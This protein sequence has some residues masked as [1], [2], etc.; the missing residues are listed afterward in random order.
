MLP[1]NEASDVSRLNRGLQLTVPSHRRELQTYVNTVAG[2][3]SALANTAVGRIVLASGTYYLSAELNI[4]RSV[5]LEAAVAGSVVLD[6]QA[7]S[8]ISTRV[9]NVNPGSLGVVQLIGLNVTGGYNNIDG[10]GVFINSGTVTLSSCTITG[11]TADF[12]GGGV[13]VSGGTVTFSSCTITGST[14]GGGVFVQGGS[15]TFDSC[16]ITGNTAYS[17]GGGVVIG[18]G[19]VSFSSCTITGNTADYGGGA[20]VS[21]GTV[22]FSSCSITGNTASYYGGGVYVSGGTV[23]FSSCTIT[24]NTAYY[25]GGGG[26]VYI[27]NGMVSFSSCTITGNTAYNGGGVAVSGG[28]VTISSC[29]ISGNAATDWGGGIYVDGGKVSIVNSQVYSNQA[30]SASNVYV[31]SI[32]AT[33]CSWATTLIGGVDGTVSTCQTPPPS[34][35]PLPPS[36][37]PSPPTSPP[38]P[39]PPDLAL[40][41]ATI[42]SNIPT[43]IAF[44]GTALTDGATCAFLPAGDDTCAGAAGAA[45]SGLFPTGGVLSRGLVT[46]RLSGP[47]IYKL[48]AAPA[49]SDPKLD[50]HF[51]YVSSVLL[52]SLSPSP[53]KAMDIGPIAGG[54][55]GGLLLLAGLCGL[56]WKLRRMRATPKISGLELPQGL[57]GSVSPV[58]LLESD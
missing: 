32:G 10:G 3:T 54:V 20:Y 11:N 22:T 50:A 43:A 23:T 35:P 41:P 16:T 15:V 18:G 28:T 27:N 9:L 42:T 45:A 53:D 21:G 13:Y 25:Y 34:L 37:P 48:C 44:V 55:G 8:S 51:T 38:P 17:W 40:I 30:D 14:A 19:T 58:R 36:L 39:P 7:S 6:A 2:L 47:M 12:D 1:C 31:S 24:G 29:I 52:T 46:V 49:G 57:Q 5:I 26:G 33:V 4:T 56:A